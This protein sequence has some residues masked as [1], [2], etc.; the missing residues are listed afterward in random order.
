[1]AQS[2]TFVNKDHK[3][4]NI[5]T[6]FGN[7]LAKKILFQTSKSFGVIEVIKEKES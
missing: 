3:R 1:M 2:V 5:L 7:F 4:F 6:L